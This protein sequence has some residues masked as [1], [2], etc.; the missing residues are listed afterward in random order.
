[1]RF[2]GGEGGSFGGR[3]GE[4][5]MNTDGHGWN[6]H[7]IPWPPPRVPNLPDGRLA[8]TRQS[9]DGEP[10]P[11]LLFAEPGSR[12]FGPS[13]MAAAGGLAT[14]RRGDDGK[15]GNGRA[16]RSSVPPDGIA[17]RTGLPQESRQECRSYERGRPAGIGVPALQN[18]RAGGKLLPNSNGPAEGRD[19]NVAPTNGNERRGT[20]TPPY[21]TANGRRG[22]V[23][24]PYRTADGRRERTDL[25]QNCMCSTR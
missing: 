12:P 7:P 21:R 4:P 2:G 10:V 1:M 8:Q 14:R 17:R 3:E 18:G 9:Y 16:D 11:N 13:E 20:E 24:P 22:S 25:R 19:R 5:Q 6:G 15:N 23:S